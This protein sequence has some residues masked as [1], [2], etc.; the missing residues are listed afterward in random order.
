MALYSLS[1]SFPCL[2][3]YLTMWKIKRIP[4]HKFFVQTFHCPAKVQISRFL[5]QQ[6]A[7]HSRMVN[8]AKILNSTTNP[9]CTL[10]FLLNKIPYIIEIFP[11][12]STITTTS[13]SHTPKQSNYY[14]IPN[15][16]TPKWPQNQN[17]IKISCT[18]RHYF[19]LRK[20]P[21]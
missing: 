18:I 6:S 7:V 3:L 11:C 15:S 19:F 17:K 2:S 1:F 14:N 21:H 9:Y 16:H 8:L 13:I 10:N 20:H 5:T 4:N 12:S